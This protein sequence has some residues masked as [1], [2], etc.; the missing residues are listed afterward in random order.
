MATFDFQE[1]R[2]G[3]T[4]EKVFLDVLWKQRATAWPKPGAPLE[5]VFSNPL[6]LSRVNQS[7]LSGVMSKWVFNISKMEMSQSLWAT[8]ASVWIPSLYRSFFLIFLVKFP[9]FQSVPITS[10]PVTVYC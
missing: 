6:C 7:R 3:L 9:L 8:Y 1:I 4:M 10:C 5:T 2:S